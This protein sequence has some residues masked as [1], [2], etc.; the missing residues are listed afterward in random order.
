[1]I[2]I[3]LLREGIRG[4]SSERTVAASSSS[5]SVGSGGALLGGVTNVAE[6]FIKITLFFVPMIGTMVYENIVLSQKRED[7]VKLEAENAKLVQETEGLDP[8]IK[9]ARK[10]EEE[11]N[12]LQSQI[13]IIKKLSKERLNNVRALS[14]IQDVIPQKVWLTSLKFEKEK[15]ELKGLSQ[16]RTEVTDF[17]NALD[18]SI[19]F[20]DVDLKYIQQEMGKEGSLQK[21]EATA[22][23]ENM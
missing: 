15:V 11:K 2:R 1:M 22:K 16:D 5:F 8:Q 13:E 21:F 19:Y 17:T 6:L 3:N 12:R 9:A 4:S 20:Q 23:L 10:L 14:A 18:T 7:V